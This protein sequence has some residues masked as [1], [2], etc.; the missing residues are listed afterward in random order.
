MQIT[1]KEAILNVDDFKFEGHKYINEGNGIYRKV[2]KDDAR[3]FIHWILE[4]QDKLVE[5]EDNY[6]DSEGRAI[7]LPK[8]RTKVWVLDV[9]SVS[10]RYFG[11]D[12]EVDKWLFSIGDIF[13]D[14]ESAE[15]ELQRLKDKQAERMK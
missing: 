13:K 10:S 8:N 2:V 9:D 6:W 14:K 4:N 12:C 1:M 5:V 11:V 15:A 3:M 7:V